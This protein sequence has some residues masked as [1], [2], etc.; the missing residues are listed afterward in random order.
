MDIIQRLRQKECDI[1]DLMA[2]ALLDPALLNTF[3]EGLRYKG[4]TVRYNCEKIM[5][6]VS[7]DHPSI[8]YPEWDYF[9][10]LLDSANSFHRCCALN[11]LANLTKIDSEKKFEKCFKKYFSLLQD[12]K[13][14]PAVFV[15]R[16]A[17]KIM[18]WKPHLQ[19]RILKILL[20]IDC[21]KRDPERIDLIKADIIQSFDEIFEQC[22]KKELLIRFV[23]AQRMC[24]SPKTRKIADMFLQTHAHERFSNEH[25]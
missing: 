7:E 1:D 9:T 23:E 4:E 22:K 14:I 18:R 17:G 13:L 3:L 25:V 11:I 5:L 20:A 2:M 24:K 21:T 6:R 12:E 19:N 15:S 10:S 8:L 16:N